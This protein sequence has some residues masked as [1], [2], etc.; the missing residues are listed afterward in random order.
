MSPRLPDA[1]Q[2]RVLVGQY[3]VNIHNLRCFAFIHKPSFMQ[4][5]DDE[6]AASYHL[7]ALLYII[8][9]LGAQ[10]VFCERTQYLI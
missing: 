7:N 5:L 6:L 8:C 3:F 1:E 4:I 2:I 10:W 9:A